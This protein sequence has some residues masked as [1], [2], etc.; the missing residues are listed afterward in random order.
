MVRLNASVLMLMALSALA[1]AADEVE[2]HADGSLKSRCALDKHHLRQGA[3]TAYHPGGK[4]VAEKAVYQAGKL[5]GQ[6]QRFD[7]KGTVVADEFW[8]DGRLVFPR[9]IA[10]IEQ[11]RKRIAIETP[12]LVKALPAATDPRAPKPEAQV[13]ALEKLRVYRFLANVPDDVALDPA[14]SECCQRGA[15]LMAKL[16][17]MEWQPTKPADMSDQ[18]F[19]LARRGCTETNQC[20]GKSLPESID[21]LMDDSDPSNI[22]RLLHRRKM[23]DPK[24][25]VTG[26][27][28]ANGYV[29]VH[30]GD[31]TRPQAIDVDFVAWPPP[32]YCPSDHF[33]PTTAWHIS[34]N[35][36]R[37]DLIDA[38]TPMDIYPGDAALTRAA[39]PL[40]LDYRHVGFDDFGMP[41]AI[42]IRP[43]DFALAKG[44]LYEVV[45]TGLKPKGA[46]PAS[47]SYFVSFY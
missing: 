29:S 44:T 38:G 22:D 4:K 3:F 47:V 39:R 18:V 36:D 33:A 40:E 6:R 41:G 2:K 43:K 9:S 16:G 13:Q 12:A 20:Y 37:Y 23:L 15:E 1:F 26:F 17:H 10:F 30:A 7:D 32:G 34:F 42:V 45:L 35:P 21:Q 46:H 24:A 19:A 5:V 11:G 8:V 28:E 25:R 14:L 27:G 31:K